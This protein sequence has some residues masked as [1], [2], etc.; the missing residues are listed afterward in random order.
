MTWAAENDSL[1]EG[2]SGLFLVGDTG[3]CKGFCGRCVLSFTTSEGFASRFR[4]R[5]VEAG[6]GC[7]GIPITDV[8][9]RA[10]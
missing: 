2:A 1:D 7:G 9:L 5:P 6:L 8:S 4:P 10:G 3:A